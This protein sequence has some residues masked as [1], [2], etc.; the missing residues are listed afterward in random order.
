MQRLK[1]KL[2]DFF[3]RKPPKDIWE[4]C[5]QARQMEVRATIYLAVA[6]IILGLNIALLLIRLW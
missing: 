6:V 5:E 3:Y 4:L 1:Q 2:H